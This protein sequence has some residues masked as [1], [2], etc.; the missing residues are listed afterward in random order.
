MEIKTISPFV[1]NS[2]Q[3]PPA[4]SAH[5]I[6]SSTRTTIDCGMVMTRAFA[7]FKLSTNAIQ[8][9]CSIRRSLDR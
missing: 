6:T 9:G 2:G 3:L 7:V 1:A 5:R 8:V 4:T